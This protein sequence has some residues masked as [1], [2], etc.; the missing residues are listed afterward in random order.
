MTEAFNEHAHPEPRP[1]TEPW[2]D[3]SQRL[4]LVSTQPIHNILAQ[5]EELGDVQVTPDV[6]HDIIVAANTMSP[7]QVTEKRREL[8]QKWFASTLKDVPLVFERQDG[9]APM[10]AVDPSTYSMATRRIQRQLNRLDVITKIQQDT[11]HK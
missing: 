3:N 11:K 1:T 4:P 2:T 10:Q 5:F 8:N 6:A 7:D 9:R